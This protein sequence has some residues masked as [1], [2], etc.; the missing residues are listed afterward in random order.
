LQRLSGE[1]NDADAWDALFGYF[2]QQKG[3]GNQGCQ[4]GEKFAIKVNLTTCNIVHS[5]SLIDPDTYDKIGFLDKSD[6]SPQMIVALLRQLVHVV[7]VNQA[8][9]SVGDPTTYFPNQWWDICQGEFPDVNYVDHEGKFGRIKAEFSPVIQ[10]WSHDLDPNLFTVDYVPRCYAE[11]DYLI[12]LAVLKGH[13]AGVTL[14]AKNHY[15]SYIRM[16]DT[17]G[18]Y[19]LHNSLGG[20]DTDSG[21]YRAL[22]DIMGH[23]HVGGKT[24]LY[25]LDGLY[26][27]YYWQ[28]TPYKFQMP[29]FNNDWPSS[30]LVSQDPVAI[31]SVGLDFLWEE[32]PQVVRVGGVDDYLKEAALM[33]DP[34]SQTIYDPAGNGQRLSSLGVHERWNNPVDKQYSR[35]LGTGKGIELVSHRIVNHSPLVEAFYDPNIIFVGY[36]VNLKGAVTDDNLP[37]SPG[38]VTTIWSK[39]SGPG[40]VTF[41]DPNSVNATAAF[42]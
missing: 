42:S 15:G 21:R 26:G 6:T 18:Y 38:A 14:C 41:V 23:P 13:G 22:V 34:C 20:V 4:P 40:T 29:P 2:N 19:N 30:L 8:D 5:G 37:V 11:A 17:T 36:P 7:G 3:K 28:G 27:G 25:L 39:V 9:I 31:D 24:L 32:W 16:P 10:H 33:A 12:N 1:P 35:N